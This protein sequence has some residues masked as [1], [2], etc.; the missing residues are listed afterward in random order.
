M[1]LRARHC[2]G[3]EAGVGLL[4]SRFYSLLIYSACGVILSVEVNRKRNAAFDWLAGSR[5][6]KCDGP[7]SKAISQWHTSSHYI[8]ISMIALYQ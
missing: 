5:Y 7:E 4:L 2:D 6:V 1:V 3:E 8:L